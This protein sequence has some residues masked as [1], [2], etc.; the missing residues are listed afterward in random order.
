MGGATGEGKISM[1]HILWIV[2]YPELEEKV[3]KIYAD[4]FYKKDFCVDIRVIKAEDIEKTLFQEEYDLL[5]GRGRSAALLKQMYSDKSVLE[6]QFTGYDMIRSLR[7]AKEKFRSKKA[8]VIVSSAN[9]HDENLLS[10]LFDMEVSVR[11]VT[12]FKRAEDAVEQ[13]IAEQ[14]D[15]VIGGYSLTSAAKERN[16][17]AITIKTGEEAVIQIFH[18]AVRMMETIQKERER[19]KLYETITQSSKEGIVYVDNDGGIQLKNKK[20]LQ[21]IS[22]ERDT[23]DEKSIDAVYPVFA[24]VFHKVMKNRQ[25]VYNELQQ[26]KDTTYLVDYVPVIVGQ[27]VAGVVITCQTVKRLQQIE[28]QLRK[29]LSEKGLVANYNFEDVIYKSEIMGKTVEIAN[30][31]AQ[32]S[33]NILIVGETGTGK[34]LMAQSIHNASE[35]RNGPFVA[36]NCAALPENLL[37]SELF[38]YVDGAFTGSKKGGKVGFFEQANHGTLFLDEISEIPINFQ[39][40]LLRAL[41]ERQVRRIGD[42]K[43]IDV[44]ARIIAA[45]NKNLKQ[46][47]MSKEFRQDLLY[48]LD[49]LKI[50]IPALRERKEDILPLFYNFIEKYNTAFGKDISRGSKEA[51]N[52]LEQYNFEGNIRELRNLAERISVMC[53]GDV[54]DEKLMRTALYPEDIFAVK[55]EDASLNPMPQE[56]T[57]RD[58]ILEALNQTGGSKGAAAELLGMDRSTLWRKMKMYHLVES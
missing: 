11:E 51:E 38:G 34:E 48:R 21:M 1:F 2:P 41:Q 27:K 36:V 42:D 16:M 28:S 18:E 10:S 9:K 30:K 8:A 15:T 31:Y 20:I 53:E 37:E 57:E 22:R 47:V 35:R 25:P 54:I 56:K 7:E 58:S 19:R 32:V 44:D 50:Y 3:K 29:K 6:I 13:M 33:S 4:L 5:I 43:V 14:Y 40:K 39:G 26:V 46:M 24:D 55:N 12:D 23:G 45:T 52:L 17:N 49:V